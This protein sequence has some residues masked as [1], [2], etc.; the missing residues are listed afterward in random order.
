VLEKFDE[1]KKNPI[2]LEIIKT[3]EGEKTKEA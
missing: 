3:Y 1:L 2:L